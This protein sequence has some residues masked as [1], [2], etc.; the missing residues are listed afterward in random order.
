MKDSRIRELEEKVKELQE[1]LENRELGLVWEETIEGVPKD[2]SYKEVTTVGE[3]GEGD[4]HLLIEGDNLHSLTLLEKDYH[5]KVG[6]IYIDPPYNTGKTFV[7]KDNR[8]DR[9]NAYTHSKWLSFMKVRLEKGKTLLREDGI[10][11]VSIDDNEQ[12][13][14]R[15]LMDNVFGEDNFIA[16]LPRMT[17]SQR[18][19]H[20]KYVSVTHDY[21]MI[22]AK[23]KDHLKFNRVIQRDLTGAKRD[24]IG[25]YFENNTRPVL[26]SSTHGYSESC[27]YDFEYKGKVY[28][29]VTAKGERRRWLWNRERMERAKELGILVP[30]KTGIRA[31]AYVDKEYEVGTNKLIDKD[32]RLVLSSKDLMESKYTND[33]G[34]RDLNK[35]DLGKDFD[36]A[37]PVEL[38][39]LIIELV[40]REDL[41]V[42]DF[43]GGSGTT[44][45]AVLEM[46]KEK[47]GN[48]QFIVCTNNEVSVAK[49]K[50]LLY[51][52]G[53]LRTRGTKE[54]ETYK[55]ENPT[56][57]IDFTKSDEYQGLGIA[58]SVT[59]KRL[60]RA[61][62]GYKDNNALGGEMKYLRI[63][64]GE[65]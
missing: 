32:P 51:Q 39:K 52:K 19:S 64:V 2:L 60:E 33:K 37:K 61:I 34:K 7:Y 14:L 50:E 9:G 22:Y 54:Y 31:K 26:A 13:Q 49:E 15:L 27:D 5:E 1:A 53:E 46:N 43:F 63:N 20:A 17:S 62:N 29:P 48:R 58:R 45:Q 6:L 40:D 41:I 16:N 55:Q 25:I 10:I 12:A 44:G 56:H 30:T 3:S 18:M 11:A 38:I 36:F 65:E 35:Y 42:L 57:Y 21:V 59:Y 24:N 47:G 4:P 28:K 8:S 23:N